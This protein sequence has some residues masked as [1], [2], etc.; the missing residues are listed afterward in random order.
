MRNLLK[1][2]IQ[3]LYIYLFDFGFPVISLD[4]PL[5]IIINYFSEIIKLFS[6]IFPQQ[7]SELGVV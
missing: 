7:I 3:S 2:A 6:N 5:V 1:V 4:Y